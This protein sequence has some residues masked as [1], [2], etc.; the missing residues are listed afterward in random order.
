MTTKNVAVAF[1]YVELSLDPTKL[2]GVVITIPGQPVQIVPVTDD[3]NTATAS[4]SFDLPPG[5]YVAEAQR[6]MADNSPVGPLVTSES[7][8]VAEPGVVTVKVAVPSAVSVS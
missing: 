2:G 3:G 8:T 6:I 5:T 1:E 7:F 4:A